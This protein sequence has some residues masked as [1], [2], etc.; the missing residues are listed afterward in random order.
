MC[1]LYWI[2]GSFDPPVAC[3]TGIV[4]YSCAYIG[5]MYIYVY[6]YRYRYI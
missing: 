3:N 2:T 5:Y 1:V 4:P 6:R